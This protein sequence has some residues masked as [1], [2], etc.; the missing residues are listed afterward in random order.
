M[1]ISPSRAFANAG[2]GR[3]AGIIWPIPPTQVAHYAA[4][5]VGISVVMW[6]AGMTTSKWTG[7]VIAA[8]V[9]VLV[10]THTRTALIAMLVGILVAGLSLFLSRRR[11]RRALVVVIVV[12]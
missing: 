2:G 1:A 6:L 10:L 9:V 5:L 12:V 11:V 7:M 8:G 4:V 3:L